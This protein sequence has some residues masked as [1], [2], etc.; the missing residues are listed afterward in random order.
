LVEPGHPGLLT[1]LAKFQTVR[2]NRIREMVSQLNRLGIPLAAEVVFALADCR[3]PGRPHIARAL[4]QAGV[5]AHLDEA[6]ERFLKKGRPAWVPKFKTSAF[7][8]IALLHRAGGLAVL[9]HP[10]LTRSDAFISPL[11]EAGLDGLECFHPKHSATAREYYV[12]ITTELNLLV[13]GG[14]D[15]HGFSKGRPVMGTVKLSYAHVECLKAR[16]AQRRLAP[17]A[18]LLSAS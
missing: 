1:E 7:E 15:C 14:S 12:R 11:A 18:P 2:Q 3:S 6:F 10:G 13:T 5:C 4:V 8:A 17:P 9:A 16:A